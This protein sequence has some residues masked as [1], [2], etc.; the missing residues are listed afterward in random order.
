MTALD[1]VDHLAAGDPVHPWLAGLPDRD[2]SSL[3]AD[4]A[5]AGSAWD[6]LAAALRGT[7]ARFAGSGLD[8]RGREIAR[9]RIAGAAS[10]ALEHAGEIHYTRGPRRWE[11]IDRD[12]R[13]W[14]GEFPRH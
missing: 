2:P 5:D 9:D 11:G 12:L 13:A 14:R 10:L 4:R 8:E 3:S 7:P 6:A 1:H